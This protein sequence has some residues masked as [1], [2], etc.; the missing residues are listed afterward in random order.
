MSDHPPIAVFKYD[1]RRATVARQRT[2]LPP[3]PRFQTEKIVRR[4]TRLG[5]HYERSRMPDGPPRFSHGGWNPWTDP[6]PAEAVERSLSWLG[7]VLRA[8][9]K[10]VLH[11]VRVEDQLLSDGEIPAA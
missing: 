7:E 5:G 8:E 9:G 4:R 10:T 11:T 6:P 3:I 2:P 1:L